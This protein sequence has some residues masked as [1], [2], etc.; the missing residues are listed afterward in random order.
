MYL[1]VLVEPLGDSEYSWISI[2]NKYIFI[3]F[4]TCQ[5]ISY[6]CTYPGK[7]NRECFSSENTGF[8]GVKFAQLVENLLG[9]DESFIGDL[10]IWPAQRQLGCSNCPFPSSH[11]YFLRNA[12]SALLSTTLI[13][14]MCSWRLVMVECV[15]DIG[16]MSRRRAT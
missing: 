5:A 15:G 16:N 8:I 11:S 3:D 1:A 10:G 4:V 14:T 2:N 9:M 7:N 13:S 6:L 12:A